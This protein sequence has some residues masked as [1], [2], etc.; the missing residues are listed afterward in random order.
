MDQWPQP[1]VIGDGERVCGEKVGGDK[2]SRVEG[3]SRESCWYERLS[4]GREES[5]ALCV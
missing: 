1:E 3:W 5:R 2:V 4:L